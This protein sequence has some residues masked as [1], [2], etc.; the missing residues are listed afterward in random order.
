M[1]IIVAVA[2]LVGGFN[3]ASAY[4]RICH[5]RYVASQLATD[6]M[7]DLRQ[8]SYADMIALSPGS[9]D[10]VTLEGID[11][12]RQW[13]VSAAVDDSADGTPDADPD[14]YRQIGTVVTW[15]QGGRDNLQ[16]SLNSIRTK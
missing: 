5:G 16:L 13:T 9:S 1:M 3:K 6:K 11:F 14:D 7:E 10:Q 8:M 2:G 15:S 4:N 12:T